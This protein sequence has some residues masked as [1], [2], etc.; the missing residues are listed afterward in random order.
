MIRVPGPGRLAVSMTQRRNGLRLRVVAHGAGIGP[1]ARLRAGGRRGHLAFVPGVMAGFRGAGHIIEANHVAVAEHISVQRGVCG[2]ALLVLLQNRHFAVDGKHPAGP[3][4]ELLVA[5]GQGDACRIRDA[6]NVAGRSGVGVAVVAEDL[7]QRIRRRPMVAGGALVGRAGQITEAGLHAAALHAEG[8]VHRLQ[9]GILDALR[10]D[11]G[12][13]GGNGLLVE[14]GKLCVIG[15]IPELFVVLG[16]LGISQHAVNGHMGVVPGLG[17][18]QRLVGHHGLD[19]GAEAAVL[20][21]IVPAGDIVGLHA[22]HLI[23]IHAADELVAVAV[24]HD[25]DKRT[26]IAGN[27]VPVGIGQPD[28]FPIHVLRADLRHKGRRTVQFRLRQRLDR[29]G[30]VLAGQHLHGG[31]VLAFAAGPGQNLHRHGDG[32][33]ALT[34]QGPVGNHPGHVHRSRVGGDHHV[35]VARAEQNR[36]ILAV[37]VLIVL[38]IGNHA[39]LRRGGELNV[40]GDVGRI[41]FRAGVEVG[42]ADFLHGQLQQLL[43]VHRPG[44]RVPLHLHRVRSGHGQVLPAV[45]DQRY[46]QR[47]GGILFGQRHRDLIGGK[48]GRGHRFHGN[49]RRVAGGPVGRG[50][51]FQI[52]AVIVVHGAAVHAGLQRIAGQAGQVGGLRHGFRHRNPVRHSVQRRLGLGFVQRNVEQALRRFL[53]VGFLVGQHQRRPDRTRGGGG[54]AVFVPLILDGTVGGDTHIVPAAVG[55]LLHGDGHVRDACGGQLGAD[56]FQRI[57]VLA[58]DGVEGAGD[59]LLG[60]VQLFLRF[61]LLGG[62]GLGPV[63][64]EIVGLAVRAAVPAVVIPFPVDGGAVG[65]LDGAAVAAL[66]PAGKDV[67]LPAEAAGRQLHILAEGRILIG[68][69]AGGG[70]LVGVFDVILDD[71]PVIAPLGNQRHLVAGEHG[72]LGDGLAEGAVGILDV[73]AVQCFVG[74][75]IVAAQIRQAGKHLVRGNRLVRDGVLIAVAVEVDGDA[76]GPVGVH[77]E[78]VFG[79][80]G[81]ELVGQ[82]HRIAA[83]RRIEPAVKDIA[84]ADGVLNGVKLAGAG[85]GKNVIIVAAHDAGAGDVR[86]ALVVQVQGHVHRQAAPFGR[87]GHGIAL[88]GGQILH[89]SAVGIAADGG[90]A[91]A[92]EGIAGTGEGTSGQRD[93]LIIDGGNAVHLSLALTGAERDGVGDGAPLS[94]VGHVAGDHRL[95]RQLLLTAEPALKQV[96]L[97]GGVGGNP[98]ADGAVLGNPHGGKH[99][100]AVLQ[101]HRVGIGP[102]RIQVQIRF[103]RNGGA[104]LIDHGAVCGGG[105]TG[106]DLPGAGEG[107]GLQGALAAENLLGDGVVRAVVGVERHNQRRT[108][109]EIPQ[110]DAV[111]AI[112]TGAVLLVRHGELVALLGVR[113]KARPVHLTAGVLDKGGAAQRDVALVV[114]C[115][116]GY[117]VLKGQVGIL[118]EGQRQRAGRIAL[119]GATGLKNLLTVLGADLPRRGAG[120]GIGGNRQPVK[121]V[122][123]APAGRKDGQREQAKHHDDGQRQ[124]NHAFFHG[125]HSFLL[126]PFRAF[127]PERPAKKNPRAR[128]GAAVQGPRTPWTSESGKPGDGRC[129]IRR[130]TYLTHPDDA[131]FTVTHSRGFA[132]HSACPARGQTA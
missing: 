69:G 19:A 9:I 110:I 123:H 56:H 38:P 128:T 43:I 55:G 33:G 86:R 44:R 6:G 74:G 8:N 47:H 13:G 14:L 1:D 122:V 58:V 25:L 68:H 131:G 52:G 126:F 16:V 4:A 76:L 31:V 91:P 82:R 11:D 34:G 93:L 108:S 3:A 2:I 87:H 49:H 121:I 78:A 7:Q 83:L 23:G 50:P 10:A 57:G 77:M 89:R 63:G 15:V 106:E 96:A 39:E 53:G 118:R 66:R 64:V 81:G 75:I 24:G 132:P 117:L 109:G 20:L 37:K 27:V 26:H 113:L 85:L 103:R 98:A 129:R 12:H 88:L 111:V 127:R 46:G 5:G 107:I 67:A 99:T 119:S 36:R 94:G 40:G 51:Q 70:A 59:G 41:E 104:V 29:Q 72:V 92:A 17:H 84:G 105:P 125:F 28:A 54:A 35:V 42:H 45:I 124:R 102:D 80:L 62:L 65:I 73:P 22:H 21:G 130:S 101:R 95:R 60:G 48:E 116:A 18:P 61:L 71:V 97:L 112:V 120:A 90:R 114:F 30:D 79:V 115:L 100:V 32:L